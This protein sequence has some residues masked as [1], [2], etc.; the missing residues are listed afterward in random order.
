M[1]TKDDIIK[2]LRGARK[3]IPTYTSSDE[4]AVL[5]VNN[6][7]KMFWNSVEPIEFDFFSF[8]NITDVYRIF[9]QGYTITE[10]SFE[11][12][13]LLWFYGQ[14]INRVANGSSLGFLRD[15]LPAPTKD[16]T[17]N[18]NYYT[19]VDFQENVPSITIT[20]NK[21][22]IAWDIVPGYVINGSYDL[23]LVNSD[24]FFNYTDINIKHKTYTY[25]ED[26]ATSSG[27]KFTIKIR[28]TILKQNYKDKFIYSYLPSFSLINVN[29]Y[30]LDEAC[31][32]TA[33]SIISDTD[34]RPN[35]DFRMNGTEFMDNNSFRIYEGEIGIGVNG[36][37]DV[38]LSKGMKTAKPGLD[39]FYYGFNE[40]KSHRQYEIRDN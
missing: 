25:N 23:D 4:G 13:G 38:N 24:C 36:N 39:S 27:R 10:G 15:D 7:G 28:L 6:E 18:L 8:T 9:V 5:S 33:T 14:F 21:E 3:D 16:V 12:I 31:T 22:I 20:P 29:G 34:L 1:I 17:G 19:I 37:M 32:I 30:E 40:S 26:F 35:N 2:L 11:T